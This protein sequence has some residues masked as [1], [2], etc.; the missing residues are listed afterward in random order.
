VADGA[1]DALE[2]GLSRESVELT[3]GQAV[4]GGVAFS[5]CE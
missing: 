3:V 5:G 2:K 1:G 4:A